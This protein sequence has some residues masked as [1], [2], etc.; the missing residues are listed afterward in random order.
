MPF[1]KDDIGRIVGRWPG[2]SS[3]RNELGVLPVSPYDDDLRYRIARA[4][5]GNSNVLALR[6]DGQPA[7]SHH[8]ANAVT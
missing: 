1:K 5:Y 6:R 2:V 7:D 8:R 4:I 3:V